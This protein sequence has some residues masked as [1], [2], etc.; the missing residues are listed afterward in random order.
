MQLTAGARLGPYEILDAVGAGGMGQVYSARDPRRG[1]NVAIKILTAA[2]ADPGYLRRF[3]LEARAAAA[4]T[5]PNIVSVYDIG[6][7]AGASYIVSELLDGDT[8]RARLDAVGALPVPT[9]VDYAAQT[10][11]GLDA[12]HGKGIV[13]RDLKPE[14]LFITRDG[15]VKILDFGLAT[16][17]AAGA[18]DTTPGM[19]LG[20][21]GYMSPEQ[22]RGLQLDHRSDIFALGAILYEM[23]AGQ[24]AFS[25]LSSADAIGAILD[26]DPPERPLAERRIPAVLA[27]IVDRCLKKDPRARFQSAADVLGGLEGRWPE[28]SL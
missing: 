18:V 15:R 5:H 22:V 9:A 23:L 14:N 21:I 10:A 19:V 4:L 13:H 16:Q 8:L 24:R 26:K 6:T 11:R 3:E 12:A 7:D 17:L 20:T 27:Q 1:Q 25:G 2:S 28:T